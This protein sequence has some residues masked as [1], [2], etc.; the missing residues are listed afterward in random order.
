MDKNH[1][2]GFQEFPVDADEGL[3]AEREGGVGLVVDVVA[4]GDHRVLVHVV[5]TWIKNEWCL[6]SISVG[7]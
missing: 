3:E 7:Q 4:P 1:P 5:A 2:H 6:E